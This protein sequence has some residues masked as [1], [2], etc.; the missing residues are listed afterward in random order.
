MEVKIIN[1]TADRGMVFPLIISS[2]LTSTSQKPPSIESIDEQ[3]KKGKYKR[4]PINVLESGHTTVLEHVVFTLQIQDISR[5]LAWILHYNPFYNTTQQSQRYVVLSKPMFYNPNNNKIFEDSVLK[6]FDGY[7][8]LQKDLEGVVLKAYKERFPYRFKDTILKKHVK[9]KS[10]EI[11]RY[12]LPLAV[13]TNLTHTVNLLTILRY[14]QYFKNI[15]LFLEDYIVLDNTSQARSKSRSLRLEST[16]KEAE[17][18]SRSLKQVLIDYDP[19]LEILISK[20]DSMIPDF[21]YDLELIALKKAREFDYGLGSVDGI[22]YVKLV[23]YTPK[24]EHEI[25]KQ[26]SGNWKLQINKMVA[27][28]INT[29][30]ISQISGILKKAYYVFYEK[31]SHS[32]ESQNQR[33]RTTMPGRVLLSLNSEWYIPK[34]I[35]QDKEILNSYNRFMHEIWLGVK[36]SLNESDLESAVYLLPN[37]ALVRRTKTVDYPNLL[38]FDVLRLCL[39]TQEEVWNLALQETVLV[40]KVHPKLGDLLLPKCSHRFKAG[41]T[42][43]C[44]E[45]LN[46]CGIEVWKSEFERLLSLD[47]II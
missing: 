31:M 46:Y 27:T 28:P 22:P 19:R 5:L 39:H 20:A 17:E 10:G 12:V 3:L 29:L 14:I 45:G 34:L 24:E 38:H 8:K 23:E 40:R 7:K 33:H 47:R 26:L 13:N 42:P 18:F 41:K 25:L 21:S 2:A 30:P 43:Y 37:A 11:A 36:R 6:D 9:K 15:R 32:A 4:L 35:K 16:L 44:N 1:S